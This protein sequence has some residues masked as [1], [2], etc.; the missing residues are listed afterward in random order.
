MSGVPLKA[1]SHMAGFIGEE[2]PVWDIG[3]HYAK[4]EQRDMLVKTEPHGT[5]LSK[6]FKGADGKLRAVVLM[7]GHGMTVRPQRPKHEWC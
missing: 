2:A 1:C 7:R 4:G 5:A 3:E 6:S